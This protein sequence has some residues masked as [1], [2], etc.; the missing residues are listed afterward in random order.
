MSL[1]QMTW[2]QY[3]HR[4]NQI[5]NH[6]QERNYRPDIVV[7]IARGGL[8]PMVSISGYYKIREVGI[9]F[10]RKT[11]TEDAFSP[12]LPEAVCLGYGIPFSIDGRS[13][14]LVD[15]IIQTG[16]TVKGASNILLGLGAKSIVIASICKHKGIYD[17]DYY[18]PMEVEEDDWVVFPWD[19]LL[20]GNSLSNPEGQT[21][22]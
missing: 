11:A 16:Q 6:F 12:M 9:V 5:L 22:L 17:F 7:G 15:N 13:I 4:M 10:M 18:S 2:E 3:I 20:S 8:L 1:I 21:N 14:L 19:N